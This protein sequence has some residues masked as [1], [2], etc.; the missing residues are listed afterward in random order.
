MTD[1]FERILEGNSLGLIDVIV[2]HLLGGNE[3]NFEESWSG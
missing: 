1:E 3:E 2:Q